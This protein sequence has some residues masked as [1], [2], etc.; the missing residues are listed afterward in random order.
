MVKIRPFKIGRDGGA[1]DDGGHGGLHYRVGLHLEVVT[2]RSH[3]QGVGRPGR[4]LPD[5]FA[6]LH[7]GGHEG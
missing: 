6:V 4:V 2:R 5:D 1:E 3:A 7:P